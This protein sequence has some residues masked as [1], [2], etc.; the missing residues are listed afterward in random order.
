M[1][2]SNVQAQA[3]EDDHDENIK[4]HQRLEAYRG[5]C[6][7]QPLIPPLNFALVCNGVYRCGY[8]NSKNMTFLDRL[9]LRSIIYLSHEPYAKVNQDFVRQHQLQFFHF[10]TEGNKV[11]CQAMN[12]RDVPIPISDALRN[13]FSGYLKNLSNKF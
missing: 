5:G 12:Q 4:P 8:P 9:Q 13:L 10:P 11:S 3:I 6:S 7:Y 1:N 2:V